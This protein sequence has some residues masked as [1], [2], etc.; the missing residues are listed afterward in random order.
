MA[1][2][3]FYPIFNR[4]SDEG[5]LHIYS[6]PHFGDK[7]LEGGIFNRPSA[8]E[9]VKMINAKVGRKDTIIILGDVGD[10]EY[11]RQIRAKRKVLIMGN[12][13][14]GRSNYE[15][16]TFTKFYDTEYYNKGMAYY[17]MAGLYPGWRI[18]VEQVY[19]LHSPFI[20]WKVTADNMLF[21]EVYE[22]PLM[23]AEKLLL[24]HEPIDVPWAY[25]IHGHNHSGAHFTPGHM[26]V[27][28]DV[29]GY[30]PINMNQWMKQ[31]HMSKVQSIHRE[32]INEATARSK[33]RKA[34]NRSA[35]SRRF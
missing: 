14:A 19:D 16:Q 5:T 11:V 18:T 23:I 26:N 28:S 1:I 7:E 34:K 27:C 12:H 4:W 9:Q 10:V 20:S 2:A 24:S 30:T 3:G 17:A 15:R 13:D 32:T 21:D 33:K 29:I 22:G 35:A 6:D 31:G 8:E 25:N